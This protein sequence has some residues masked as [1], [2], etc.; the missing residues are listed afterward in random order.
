[1][2]I[3]QIV[4][5]ASAGD[6]VTDTAFRFQ[7]VLRRVGP[8]EV[9]ARYIDPRL[10]D[11]VLPLSGHEFRAEPDDILVYHLS[12]GEP[13]VVQ[14]LLGRGERLVLVYHNVTP[15]EYFAAL[16]ER[17]AALVGS[18][19]SELALLRDRTAL[20]LAGSEF[21]A[22]ELNQLGY[23][24]VRISPFPVDIRG[25]H[26]LEPD[27]ATTAAL[28]GLEGP[29]V[30]YVGQLLPHKRPD[31]LLQA[32][33]VLTTFLMPEAHLVLLGAVRL[34]RYGRAL[35]ALAAELN[36]HGA[37]IP[38]WLPADQLAAYYRRADV[39]VTMSE[40]EGVCFPLLEAM[41]FGVPVVARDFGAIP[42]TL[43]GAGVLLPAED[44]VFL[45][46]ETL[47]EV[48]TDAAVRAKL[49]DRGLARSA[50]VSADDAR[51]TFLGHLVG[52]VEGGSR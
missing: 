18:G 17:F 15:P 40:H 32:Y 8:S 7:E 38:G 44:D 48:L 49:I 16:D 47:A 46:A 13:E 35:L 31:L 34:E 6:A 45:I 20:A 2:R 27:A 50:A 29:L 26:S 21:N 33:H 24:D 30:L 43:G 51:A 12:I 41:S 19:R 5:S 23:P 1:M 28:E 25:L 37:T 3:H 10:A 42:E 36:L 9:F 11:R 4:V 22:R 39:F 14:F 52:L